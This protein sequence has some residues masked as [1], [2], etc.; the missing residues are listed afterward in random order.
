M[1]VY[2]FRANNK[3]YHLLNVFSD[4]GKALEYSKE[5]K[6][7]SKSWYNGRYW[8][9]SVLIKELDDGKFGVYRARMENENPIAEYFLAGVGAAAGSWIFGKVA[10]KK[11][12]PMNNP[13]TVQW[14]Q[15]SGMEERYQ[16]GPSMKYGPKGN[17]LVAVDVCPKCGRKRGQRHMATMKTP[18]IA[19]L[20]RWLNDGVAKATDGC[21][22]EPDGSCPH[23]H[24]SWMKV[25]GMI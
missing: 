24:N 7:E 11:R 14:E 9:A 8:Y 5:I 4:E 19:T 10:S 18:S 25:L 20:E 17:P 12:N 6:E 2:E 23:G 15:Y 1:S 3:T 16:M 13:I 21:R 22:V